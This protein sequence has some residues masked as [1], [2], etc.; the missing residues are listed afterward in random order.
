M[1]KIMKDGQTAK[2]QDLIPIKNI[3]NG[4]VQL[5]DGS[6][7]KVILVDGT[8][9][10]LKSEDEQQ[11]ILGAYQNMLNSLDFSLQTQI[12]SRKLNVEGYLEK[13]GK[14]LQEEDNSLIQTQIKEYMEFIKSFVG[15]NAIMAKSFFV[16]IPYSPVVIPTSVSKTSSIFG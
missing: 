12:H 14:Q 13:L 2:T 16:V 5:N 6:L 8:N 9:F 10:E 11:S 4:I 15:Q 7:L 1:I 3:E